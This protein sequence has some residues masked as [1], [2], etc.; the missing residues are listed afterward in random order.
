MTISLLLLVLLLL[1]MSSV[2]GCPPPCICKWRNG[3]QTVECL[4][5]SLLIIPEGIDSSTQV[6]DASGNNILHI[7]SDNFLKMGLINLQ[8]LF[9]SRCRIKTVHDEAL[10]G[11]SNLVELDLSE[12]MLSTVPTASLLNC[13]SLMKLSLNKNPI[14]S[15]EKLAFNHLSFL[16]TLDLSGCDINQVD[17]AAFRSL[18]SLE[19]M[20]L[21]GNKIKAF[22]DIRSFPNRLKGL[23]LHDNPWTCDCNIRT[24]SRW[25]KLDVLPVLLP[26]LCLEPEKFRGVPVRKLDEGDLACSPEVTDSNFYFEAEKGRNVTL[27]CKVKATP[28]A[29]VSWMFNGEILQGNAAE[30]FIDELPEGQGSNLNLYNVNT[31][32]NGTFYCLAENPAGVAIANY[33]IAVIPRQPPALRFEEDHQGFKFFPIDTRVL[34]LILAGVLVLTCLCLAAIIMA[35]CEHE[36]KIKKRKS[37]IL[38]QSKENASKV[39]GK[40]ILKATNGAGYNNGMVADGVNNGHEDSRRNP[41][42]IRGM[43]NG[44]GC[45]SEVEA[46]NLA[47][48]SLS[49]R[50]MRRPPPIIVA[51]AIPV[52][53]PRDQ[54]QPYLKPTLTGKNRPVSAPTFERFVERQDLH[55]T[56]GGYPQRRPGGHFMGRQ[57]SYSERSS[58]RQQREVNHKLVSYCQSLDNPTFCGDVNL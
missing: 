58:P 46:R 12:N 31:A 15:L 54:S 5:R 7:P 32:C 48:Y 38:E 57:V 52:R 49:Q 23:Q 36:A 17:E 18:Y 40:S 29:K 43:T 45:R 47:G 24:F 30:Y 25:L 42:I 27:V 20:D 2:K 10:K 56:I 8:K 41:D 53:Q 4:S 51:P 14:A 26:P 22:P 28:E 19:W 35:I 1:T 39:P 11:L 21:S 50:N 16:T 34:A 55:Y 44:L 13:P 9:L 3:K 6:L 33:T 37:K